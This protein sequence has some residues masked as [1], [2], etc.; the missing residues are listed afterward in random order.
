[1]GQDANAG[2]RSQAAMS[3]K[4]EGRGGRRRFN[5]AMDDEIPFGPEWRA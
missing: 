5:K 2:R 3:P 1:M 4:G